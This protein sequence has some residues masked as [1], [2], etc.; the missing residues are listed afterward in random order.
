M[1]STDVPPLLR[2]HTGRCCCTVLHYLSSS[3]NSS[4][5]SC[6]CIPARCLSRCHRLGLCLCRL[7]LLADQRR[8]RVGGD[9][10]DLSAL[11]NP[12][13]AQHCRRLGLAAAGRGRGCLLEGS[14][15][16][17]ISRRLLLPPLALPLHCHQVAAL[18]GVGNQAG[19][20]QTSLSLAPRQQPCG[21]SNGGSAAT[22]APDCYLLS[23]SDDSIVVAIAATARI[24]RPLMLLRAVEQEQQQRGSG[25]PH[26]RLLDLW[27]RRQLLA[28]GHSL[29]HNLAHTRCHARCSKRCSHW[30][31]RE[32]GAA[33]L[34][35]WERFRVATAVRRAVV[36]AARGAREA[37]R[38]WGGTPP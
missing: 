25:Q 26:D 2:L 38:V 21:S 10:A 23:E 29:P 18:L 7:L 3:R 16:R 8:L 11:C 37:V 1:A 14:C 19:S 9:P 17:L 4:C 5:C 22:T 28:G 36:P 27:G 30:C 34:C 13:H 32:L 33:W 24:H 6:S 31:C 15:S 35:H 12:L 20:L